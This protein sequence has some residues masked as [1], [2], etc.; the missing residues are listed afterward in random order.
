MNLKKVFNILQKISPKLAANIAYGFIS[1]PKINK[2]KPFEKAI[3]KTAKTNTIQFKKF[4]IKTYAW[5]T[6]KRKAFL[7]HGWGGRASNF[8]AI[9]PVLIEKGYQVIS[10]DGPSHGASTKKKTNFFEMSD[11]VKLFLQ[12]DDY[13]IIITHSM[14][15]V[16]AITAMSSLRYKVNQMILLTTPSRFLEFIGLAVTQFGLSTNTTKLLI[17]KIKKTTTYDPIK[18]K[19][20][21]LVKDITMENVT[22]IHDKNDKV[23]PIEKSKLVSSYIKNSK[24]IEIDGTGHFKMLWSKKVVE[25]IKQKID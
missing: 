19:A 25:L 23:I 15:S 8:G 11:L 16:L 1:K 18:L 4:K 7:V 17:D 2:I 10:F 12:K 3:I 6:A 13:D 9:I 24:F 20:I 22:F 21:D 5:G 14:G